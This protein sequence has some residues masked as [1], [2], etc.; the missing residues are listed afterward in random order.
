ML[1]LLRTGENYLKDILL[2]A[3]KGSETNH[4]LNNRSHVNRNWTQSSS[5]LCVNLS[6]TQSSSRLCVNLSWTQS[7]SRLCVKLS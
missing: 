4:K 6:W 2:V 3:W 1:K 7:S 5:R